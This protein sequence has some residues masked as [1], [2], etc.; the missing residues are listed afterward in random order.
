MKHFGK[1]GCLLAFLVMAWNVMALVL[2]KKVE[3]FKRTRQI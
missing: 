1:I 3:K 2:L